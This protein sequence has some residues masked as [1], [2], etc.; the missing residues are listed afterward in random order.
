MDG[1]DTEAVT[2][3]TQM[4]APSLAAAQDPGHAQHHF[5][6]GQVL[7]TVMLGATDAIVAQSDPA[8]IPGSISDFVRGF[9]EIWV[10]APA[11]PA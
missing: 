6:L 11:T 7:A 4:N 3:V 5:S 8:K 2:K 1:S 9:M 10:Q